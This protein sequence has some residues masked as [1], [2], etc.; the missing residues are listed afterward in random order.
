MQVRLFVILLV[1]LG[2]RPAGAQLSPEQLQPV[3]PMQLPMNTAPGPGTW[4]FGQPYGNTTGAY[5]FGDQW[6]R[7]G[8][9]LHF[10]LDFSMPCGTPLVALADGTVQFV[11]D[12]SFG[13]DP[14]N[15][16]IRH[17][18]LG[19]TSLYGHLLQRPP[20]T[21]GQFI[22]KGQQ[23]ALSG[24]P[25]GTCTGRPH[26]HL[27]IRSLDY[28][29]AYNPVDYID[30]N[31]HSLALIGSYGL[32]L[33]QQNLQNPRQ[34]VSITDQ[35]NV[36]FWGQILNQYTNTYPE[37]GRPTE[38]LQ[39]DRQTPGLGTPYTIRAATTDGCCANAIW[40]PTDPRMLYLMDGAPGSIASLFTLNL[41]TGE[42][43]AT[44]PAPVPHLSPNGAY[45]IES[46]INGFSKV[47]RL[48]DG[49]EYT[50]DTG[51]TLPRLNPSNTRL[52]WT[53]SA[54]VIVPGQQ[55]PD[56]AVYMSDIDGSNPREIF[57]QSGASARWLTDDRVLISVRGNERQT[58]LYVYMVEAER[59]IS[60]GTW[61]EMR[62]LRVAPGGQRISFYLSWQDNPAN[63]GVYVMNIA[64]PINA[65]AQRMPWFGSWRWRDA[66]SL[67]YVPYDPDTSQHTLRVYDLTTGDDTP[68]LSDNTPPFTIADGHWDVSADGARIAFQNAADN[69]NLYVL[70]PAN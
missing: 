6:Y 18:A 8:Q 48:S 16:I 21:E 10:G 36:R 55:R 33:F 11:D 60:L 53:V 2:V 54:N 29:Q 44:L 47:R 66:T 4:L 9:G 32:P 31:W 35:P 61:Q 30:A 40:H 5:R 46:F 43:N 23:I 12:K 34:W 26:L 63:N 19:L 27:E 20:L 13:S 52:L 15:L 14:H 65:Q 64:Q 69:R 17:D 45:E 41:L 42:R 39:L 25:D 67:Y 50:V 38:T 3:K 70:E 7:A 62:D 51:G 49:T 28:S 24:D 56:A 59:A 58:T 57:S 37:P 22:Q 1:M 68:L